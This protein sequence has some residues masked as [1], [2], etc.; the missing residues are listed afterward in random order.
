[1][2]LNN[3]KIWQKN[4]G[5]EAVYSCGCIGPQNGERYCPCMMRTRNRERQQWLDELLE[6]YDLVPK[7]DK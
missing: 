4:E 6:K 2:V 5:E 3:S 7:G 1:M